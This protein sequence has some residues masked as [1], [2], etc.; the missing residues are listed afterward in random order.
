MKIRQSLS[1]MHAVLVAVTLLAVMVVVGTVDIIHS[2]REQRARY[3]ELREQ[4]VDT[5]EQALAQAVW[6][7]DRAA[8]LEIL[9]GALTFDY[10]RR[11]A[12]YNPN[13]TLYAEAE[14]G[15][16][17][18]GDDS[19]GRMLFSDLATSERPL[20]MEVERRGGMEYTPLG[21]VRVHLDLVYVGRNFFGY[22]ARTVA[23]QAVVL[24]VLAVLVTIV[25]RR[26]L[27]QP[28]N[29]VARQVKSVQ[30]GSQNL[31]RIEAEPLHAENE[32]G[33][34]VASF[35][36]LLGRVQEAQALREEV[37]RKEYS[38]QFLTQVKQRLEQEIEERTRELQEEKRHAEMASRS[39]SVFLANMSHELRTPL[40]GVI[41]YAE[42]IRDEIMGPVQP[43]V[44]KSYAEHIH[45]SGTHMLTLIDEV[46]SLSQSE[47]GHTRLDERD[48]DVGDAIAE[49][50][51][52]LK[53]LAESRGVSLETDPPAPSPTL[54]AD[55]V[56]VRQMVLNL[57]SNAIK[58]TE[59]G[60]R[61]ALGASL[62]LEGRVVITV[63]DT[64]CGIAP[65]QIEAVMEPF[66]RGSNPM[67]NEGGGLGLGLPL[68]RR[69]MEAHGGSL[70]LES[71]LGE[72]TRAILT[73]PRARVLHAA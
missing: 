6:H 72:G 33:A 24:L 42:M 37:I 70:K 69:L 64:G 50:A 57:V 7:F 21:E 47:F 29:R 22:V 45:T 56:K 4:T 41:G 36:D 67:L 10:I 23:E 71:R 9:R 2:V 35:N 39:K 48:L 26:T 34:L 8:T 28:I 73:F 14:V 53:P 44:Y 12:V 51:A 66:N 19:I 63:S 30:P 15:A 61:V 13:G 65:D 27:T 54:K 17:A 59:A 16:E 60:G 5:I 46:L 1:T 38:R 18:Q 3:A 58:H 31:K 43:P 68:T 52:A 40:N 11:I 32:I 62:D 25:T 55:P 20:V 49:A